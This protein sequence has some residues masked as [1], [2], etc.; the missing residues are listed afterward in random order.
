MLA[1]ALK[2]DNL[3]YIP[4]KAKEAKNYWHKHFSSVHL[5]L[6]FDRY[7][8]LLTVKSFLCGKKNKSKQN[9]LKQNYNH[10]MFGLN[11]L[12]TIPNLSVN[13]DRILASG[14]SFEVLKY[15]RLSFRFEDL[16]GRS[17]S[18]VNLDDADFYEYSFNL[19]LIPF[20]WKLCRRAKCWDFK[21]WDAECQN[22]N[23]TGKCRRRHKKRQFN[24]HSTK[25]ERSEKLL[26]Q[27]L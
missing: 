6:S 26:T 12:K 3:T 11:V 1:P 19:T 18:R 16:S 13:A 21:C 20:F 7:H 9:K 23:L 15:I 8:G 10:S 4:L 27:A 17:G 25:S 24:L 14:N 22:Y 5:V 2:K